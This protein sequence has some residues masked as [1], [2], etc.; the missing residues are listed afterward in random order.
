[1]QYIS[2]KG[3]REAIA[4][5]AAKNT[6]VD[7]NRRKLFGQRMK[8]RRMELQLTQLDMATATGQTY[9]TFISNV[10]NG[11]TKIPSK[12]LKLWA[13]ALELDLYD[14]TKAYLS[15]VDQHLFEC[16]YEAS[17]RDTIL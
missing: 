7:K 15:A 4:N 5:T 9:F 3:R 13:D 17:N 12:D 10:E 2:T 11:G 14:F 1:M 16:L 6:R 8:S